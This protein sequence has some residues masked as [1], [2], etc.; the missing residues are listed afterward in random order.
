MNPRAL[1]KHFA[2]ADLQIVDLYLYFPVETVQVQVRSIESKLSTN[3]IIVSSER[4]RDPRINCNYNFC[5]ILA[6]SQALIRKVDIGISTR[7]ET[8]D[9]IQL[10]F[11]HCWKDSSIQRPHN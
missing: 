9:S 6:P 3:P 11:A 4:K 8:H 5:Y 1:M 10:C 7:N 2:E